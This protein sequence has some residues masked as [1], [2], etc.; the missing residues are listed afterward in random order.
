MIEM[1][2]TSS[3][4]SWPIAAVVIYV[5]LIIFNEEKLR[6]HVEQA[7]LDGIIIPKGSKNGLYRSVNMTNA[8]NLTISETI[9]Q[10]IIYHPGSLHKSIANRRSYKFEPSLL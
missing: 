3:I 6:E 2:D 5:A 4:A 10:M 8:L 7:S 9:H 1:I